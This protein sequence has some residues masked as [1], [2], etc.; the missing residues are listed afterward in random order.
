MK[1]PAAND[2]KAPA[3]VG[4]FTKLALDLEKCQRY[5]PTLWDRVLK[6]SHQR[7]DTYAPSLKKARKRVRTPSSSVPSTSTPFPSL[8]SYLNQPDMVRE[9][10]A[11]LNPSP[12]RTHTPLDVAVRHPTTLIPAN[13]NPRSPTSGRERSAVTMGSSPTK[14][15]ILT[16]I[17]PRTRQW[18]ARLP[19][20]QEADWAAI[21]QLES[22]ADE[23]VARNLH[24]IDN[25][26]KPHS[27]YGTLRKHAK[28][29]V[30]AS[31][32][33]QQARVARRTKAADMRDD[34]KAIADE[35]H[36]MGMEDSNVSSNQWTPGEETQHM[37]M[38][39]VNVHVLLDEWRPM[40]DEDARKLTSPPPS[41]SPSKMTTQHHVAVE[42]DHRQTIHEAHETTVAVD[43]AT[44]VVQS[45]IDAIKKWV[46]IELVYAY[47][48]GQ[49]ASMHIQLA[50]E[51]VHK[52]LLRMAMGNYTTAW[53]QWRD[54]TLRARADER[55]HAVILLQCWWRTH[56]AHQEVAIRQDL[57]RK[58]KE[59]E[60]QLLRFLATKKNDAAKCITRQ[61]RRYARACVAWRARRRD[62]AAQRIQ[63][64][65]RNR[66]AMWARFVYFLDRQRRS[67][68]ATRIQ[69]HIRAHLARAKVRLVRKL[70][71]VAQRAA[72]IQAHVEARAHA[73]RLVGAVLT[74]QRNIR[75]RTFRRRAKFGAM[76]RRHAKKVAAAIKVQSIARMYLAQKLRRTLQ[77]TQSVAAVV[78]QCAY[79]CYRSKRLRK[80]LKKERKAQQKARISKKKDLKREKKNRQKARTNANQATKFLMALEDTAK[81]LQKQRPKWLAMEPAQAAMVIQG[82]WKGFKTRK[83]LKRQVI[84]DKEAAR[85]QVNRT[86]K[87]AATCIQRHVRGMLS[88]MRYWRVRVDAYA[89]SIQRLFRNRKARRDIAYMRAYVHAALLIKKRWLEKKTFVHFR[90]Q[91]R[92]AVRIQ[93]VARMYIGTLRFRRLV[94]AHHVLVETR[95]VGQV[96]FGQRTLVIVQTQL[97]QL[98]WQFAF[99]SKKPVAVDYTRPLYKLNAA[100]RKWSTVG[101]FGL[102]QVLFL[103][104]CRHGN[105]AD[106]NEIDNMRFSRFLKEVPGMLH[107]TLCPLQTADVAFAKFKPA[108]GR[109]MPFSGFHKAMCHLLAL[110]YPDKPP[111]IVCTMEQR[112]LTFMQKLV[113][114]SK[115]GEPYRLKLTEW[116]LER[117]AW[118]AHVLQTMHRHRQQ[119]RRH[120]AFVTRFME[121]RRLDEQRRAA[122]L[123]QNKYRARLAKLKFQALVCDTFVEYVDWKSGA[124]SYKNLVTGTM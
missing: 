79:R 68:A 30:K 117:G 95:L 76:R 122:T 71:A 4:T 53:Q 104:L 19:Q 66:R 100:T 7:L 48:R 107:K 98:S 57:R 121:L 84:K 82:G 23:A 10:L 16:V 123:L 34:E 78:I 24:A 21:N 37:Q 13:E 103:D 59:R 112:F 89:T 17:T 124:C 20:P 54:Y 73:L 108:K 101:A 85:R 109:T 38:E 18:I 51:M 80:Q 96:L 64:F 90:K 3:H 114:V 110:R 91:R 86:R 63:R 25:L 41:S 1:R 94:Q 77:R 32:R 88:R 12:S 42:A 15:P 106:A 56:L 70:R 83:R 28:S 81:T 72:A 8:S 50:M 47:G 44:E 26:R 111:A 52:A 119:Q 31:S 105:T 113:L 102:W 115:F 45:T 33:H 74:V 60:R 99:D 67:K 27:L 39:D 93:S 6:R 97:L 55:V 14:L 118:A 2:G 46:P 40:A 49:Y 92:A 116:A 36:R 61:I 69:T 43:D 75:W 9:M 29:P 5:N 65:V 22:V 11:E 58:Q 120:Q 35:Q 62:A 87:A